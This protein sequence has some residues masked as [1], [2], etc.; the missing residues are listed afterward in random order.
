MQI[1]SIFLIFIIFFLTSSNLE[2]SILLDK[3]VAIVNKEVITWSDLYKTMEF[4]ASDTVKSL[5]P[6][7]KKKVFK[8]NEHSFLETM[9]DMRL[10]L[11]EAEKRGMNVS[12][13]DIKNAIEMIR[14]KYGMNKED[15]E[16]ALIQEGFTLKEY[17]KKLSEQM[18]LNKIVDQ[19]VRSKIIISEGDIDKEI[20]SKRS[21]HKELEGYVISI[22]TLPIETSKE[23]TEAKA[24]MIIDK[25]KAGESFVDL[26]RQ[27]SKDP[28]ARLGGLIGFINKSDISAQFLKLL[29]GLKEKQ[30]SE[31]FW[32]EKGLN[33]VLLN[34][35]KEIKGEKELRESVRQKLIEEAY[36]KEYKSWLK[37]LR[38]RA[39]V[40]IKI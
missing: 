29:D 31:P 40:E 37:S 12:K 13:D 22:I 1:L 33:I 30:F 3:V 27:Y 24:Q 15:F 39:Y 32:N 11:Q 21:I 18:L 25:L 10:Q 35:K 36:N 23:D 14:T 2:S 28:S 8:E 7:E 19:E 5:P 4:E 38:E 17:E 9:I 6:Q 34:Q 16:K 26:A 20:S